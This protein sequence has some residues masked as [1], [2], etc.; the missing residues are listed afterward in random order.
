MSDVAK[1]LTIPSCPLPAPPPRGIAGILARTTQ[2]RS[3]A[4]PTDIFR[5]PKADP[6]SSEVP[7]LT[8]PVHHL[9][10]ESPLDAPVSYRS[11]YRV[12]P[13]RESTRSCNKKNKIRGTSVLINGTPLR[14][15]FRASS[16]TRAIFY[17]QFIY[18]RGAT[19]PLN[20]HA[21]ISDLPPSNSRLARARARVRVAW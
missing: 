7:V 3:R 11:T 17:V 6:I 5:R 8:T 1:V 20:I 9:S 12:K 14:S 19:M 2:E 4:I 21:S 13:S 10:W 18:V 15:L 16:F